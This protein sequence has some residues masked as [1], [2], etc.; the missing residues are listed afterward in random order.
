MIMGQ[1]GFYELWPDIKMQFVVASI[2]KCTIF[3]VP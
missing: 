3:E 2:S 1:S